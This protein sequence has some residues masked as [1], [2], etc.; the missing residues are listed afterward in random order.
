MKYSL[1]IQDEEKK[2]LLEQ[3]PAII[4]EDGFG[5]KTGYIKVYSTIGEQN[6][7][8]HATITYV[9]L[10]AGIGSDMY[11]DAPILPDD[12][13]LAVVRSEDL[14]HWETIVDHRG[15][16]AYRKDDHSEYI[17]D[18]LGDIKE[19]VTWLK[20]ETVFDYWDED[21]WVTDKEA[22]KQD[23][24]QNAGYEKQYRI[25]EASRI[26]QPLQ[27]AVDLDLATADEIKQLRN[28]KRYR[29]NLHRKDISTAPDIDWPTNP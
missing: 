26:I 21:K 3:Q 5:K 20:P 23:A 25:D 14:T 19:D 29:L 24:L 12:D 7:Y 22:Q 4:G 13:S 2:N 11:L 8:F 10:H 27:D 9:S 6:E 1:E 18:Y 16:I 28:W 17:I 15:K